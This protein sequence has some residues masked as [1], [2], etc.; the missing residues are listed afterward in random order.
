[1]RNNKIKQRE[2]EKSVIKINY[3]IDELCKRI[4]KLKKLAVNLKKGAFPLSIM[5]EMIELTRLL[6]QRKTLQQK[7]TAIYDELYQMTEFAEEWKGMRKLWLERIEKDAQSDVHEDDNAKD[8]HYIWLRMGLRLIDKDGKIIRNDGPRRDIADALNYDYGKDDV[9]Y[10][11]HL[12]DGWFIKVSDR[13]HIRIGRVDGYVDET[14][15]GICSWPMSFPQFEGFRYKD[16]KLMIGNFSDGYDDP[17]FFFAIDLNDDEIYEIF[18]SE[19]K[20]IEEYFFSTVIMTPVVDEY[21]KGYNRKHPRLA[22]NFEQHIGFGLWDVQGFD[23]VKPT[24]YSQK[25][26]HKKRSRT[27]C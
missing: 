2:L 20:K 4:A 11:S 9:V 1:M 13:Y 10:F 12:G 26:S 27:T 21:G 25:H 3:D 23:I 15:K 7:A 24:Y 22:E 18:V 14:D 8:V 6:E 17:G 16:G 19:F 5:K